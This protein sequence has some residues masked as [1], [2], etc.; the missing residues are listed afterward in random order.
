MVGLTSGQAAGRWLLA[1]HAQQLGLATALLGDP[2]TLVLDEPA[3]GLDPE[4]IQWIRQLLTYLAGQDAAFF[5]PAIC[6]EM[7]LM[8]DHLVVIGKG[9]LIADASVDA[10]VATYARSGS[11]AQPPRWRR[12]RRPWSVRARPSTGTA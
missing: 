3:N 9:R 2:H 12:W 4:G 6:S 5:C 8:A 11:G 1:R 7:A 10:F